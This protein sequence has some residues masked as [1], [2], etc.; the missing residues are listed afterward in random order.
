MFDERSEEFRSPGK[1][2]NQITL[3]KTSVFKAYICNATKDGLPLLGIS[4]IQK[5]EIPHKI[6]NICSTSSSN[7]NEHK[8]DLK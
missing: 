5:A 8:S 4:P 7:N 6:C 3:R 2:R 1:T